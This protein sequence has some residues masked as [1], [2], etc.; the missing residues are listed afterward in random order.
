MTLRRA[1]VLASVAGVALLAERIAVHVIAVALPEPRRVAL[2][3]LEPAH[4][5][6]H[7]VTQWMSRVYVV[8]GSALSWSRS[9]VNGSSTS[10]NTVRFH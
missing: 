7:F 9:S 3:I 4:H 10:P 1:D 2:T 6:D 5:F 8:A